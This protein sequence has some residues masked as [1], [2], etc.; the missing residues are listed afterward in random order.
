MVTVFTPVF[1]RRKMMGRLYGSLLAQ[2]NKNFEWIIVDDGSTDDLHDDVIGWNQNNN[3]FPITYL[4]K[5]NGGKHRALNLGIKIA[6][7]EAFFV[8]DSD[9]YISSDG[10]D[11]IEQEFLKIKD[12]NG[13]AG[14]L[15]L[16]KS[17]EDGRII[18]GGTFVQYLCRYNSI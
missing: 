17:Y 3:G 9:D 18:G 13:I 16:R 12:D 10:I 5:Q 2:T 6:N 4:Y 15:S 1:N 11:F 7:Y 8:I 14:M